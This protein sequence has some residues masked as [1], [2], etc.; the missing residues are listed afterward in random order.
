MSKEE[1]RRLIKFPLTNEVNNVLM[2]GD[3]IEEDKVTRMYMFDNDNKLFAVM[4]LFELPYEVEEQF[5]N[6]FIKI[7]NRLAFKYGDA[8]KNTD[9]ELNKRGLSAS[10]EFKKSGILL[11]LKIKKPFNKLALGVL[12]FNKKYAEKYFGA[13]PVDKF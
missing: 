3:V 11:Q 7:Y 12:Y 4:I 1:I 10:W 13:Y 2:Y 6:K 8:G 9:E 5:R